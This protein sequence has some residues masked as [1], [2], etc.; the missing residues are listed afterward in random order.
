MADRTLVVLGGGTGGL[1]AAHRLRRRLD[2]TDRVVVID[3][4]PT[5]QFAPSFL[6]VMTGARRAAQ[7]SADRRR[8]RR[9][10]IEILLADA[11]EI[12]PARHRITTAETEVR[13]DRLILALGAELAPDALDGFSAAAHNLYTLEGATTAA[14]ALARFEGGRVAVVVSRLPYKC[15]AAPYEAAFLTEALLGH[16]GVCDRTTID[17]YTPEPF[18]MPTAGPVLGQALAAML[19]ERGISLHPETSVEGI[20]PDS[21]RLA[22][23]GGDHADYDLLLGIPPHRAPEVART[24]GLAAETGFVPVDPA[25][26]ATA[27]DGVYAIGDITAIPIAGGKFLPKAGVFAEAQAD[28]VATNIAAEL[29]GRPAGATFDGSGACFVELGNGRAAFATGNFYA[30]DG[31]QIRLRRAG[32]H[33]HLAKVA[34]EK[35]WMRRWT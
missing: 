31:P 14:D 23:A 24:S 27:A 3:R 20:D 33:W 2:P 18:P 30:P 7:I 6:W 34:F 16:R 15:P 19:A 13:F 22:L 35:Y 8:L 12:D 29:T 32:R 5:F 17:V 26:L 4:T 9:A 1:V 11:L 28:V 25:T 10:G 21:R